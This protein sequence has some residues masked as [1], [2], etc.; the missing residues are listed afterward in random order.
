MGVGFAEWYSWSSARDERLASVFYRHVDPGD[1]ADRDPEAVVGAVTHLI[2]MARNREPQ[3]AIVRA[4]NPTAADN[5]WS[6]GRT[7]ISVV[8]DDMPFLVDSVS[9]ELNRL[10]VGIH[11]VSECFAGRFAAKEAFLKAI[12]WGFRNGIRWTDIE[13]ENDSMG[14]PSLLFHGKA[15][16]V[17]KTLRIQKA[18][19]TLSHDRPYA[20]AH[21]I[22]EG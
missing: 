21:V 17:Y 7:V 4:V 20:V 9:A 10:G 1:I 14:R 5:G 8:T 12:G 22:L 16:A 11:L 19:L 15:E 18:L 6:C 3:Q 2:D 13:I